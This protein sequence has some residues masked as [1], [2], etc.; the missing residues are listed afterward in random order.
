[1]LL[2][3]TST[4][5]PK[6]LIPAALEATLA[7]LRRQLEERAAELQAARDR[8]D[9]AERELSTVRGTVATMK[10]EK[11]QMQGQLQAGRQT[12]RVSGRGYIV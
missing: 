1:M 5:P 8:A 2:L 12:I 10:I 7:T 6:P 9:A 4:P 3:T 11:T